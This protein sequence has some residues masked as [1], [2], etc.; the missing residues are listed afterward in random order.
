MALDPIMAKFP[1]VADNTLPPEKRLDILVFTVGTGI[2]L[3]ISWVPL[4]D[5]VYMR[6][7]LV[8]QYFV[9]MAFPSGILGICSAAIAL[10]G[11]MVVAAFR[12]F[13]GHLGLGV[14]V[15]SLIGITNTCLGM[16]FIALSTSLRSVA[17]LATNVIVWNCQND[18]LT[19]GLYQEYEILRQLR[20]RDDC[21]NHYTI[22]NCKDYHLKAGPLA[23]LLHLMEERYNCAGASQLI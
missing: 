18:A 6:Q 4:W 9:G 13:P 8:I 22:E 12:C 3:M 20:V 17:H 21:R 7:N 14:K 2:L 23:K 15:I 11:V 1:A 16:I 10:F 19:A 5:A